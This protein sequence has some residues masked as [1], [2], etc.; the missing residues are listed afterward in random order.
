MERRALL[1]AGIAG[2]LAATGLGALADPALAAD[3]AP[4]FEPAFE[5]ARRDWRPVAADVR[6]ELRQTWNSYRRLAWGHDQMLPVSGGFS[7]FFDDAH[8]VGLSIVEALDTL[9]FMGLDRE[10]AQRF[11]HLQ[12]RARRSI[13]C[14]SRD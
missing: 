11:Q 3:P 14:N 8:P 2:G 13:L 6:N 12:T 9:F 5:P 10:L 4:A 1:R 7:E